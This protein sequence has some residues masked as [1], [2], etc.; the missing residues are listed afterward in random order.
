MLPFVICWVV[1]DNQTNREKKWRHQQKYIHK[2]ERFFSIFFWINMYE[3]IERCNDPSRE[4]MKT[5]FLINFCL[6]WILS[7]WFKRT[8]LNIHK[9]TWKSVFFYFHLENHHDRKQMKTPQ[10]GTAIAFHYLNSFSVLWAYT[11]CWLF[12]NRSRIK[13]ITFIN[14]ILSSSFFLFLLRFICNAS[15][16]MIIISGIAIENDKTIF[17]NSSYVPVVV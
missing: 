1:L 8:P 15:V 2:A 12:S 4:Q 13:L 14:S 9:S 5:N 17:I 16:I 3:R 6:N 7:H 10:S 11:V